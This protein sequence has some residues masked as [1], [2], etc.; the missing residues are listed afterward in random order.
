MRL[1]SLLLLIASGLVSACQ[2]QESTQVNAAPVPRFEAVRPNEGFPVQVPSA[3]E[4]TLGWLVVREDRTD[5]NSKEIRLPVAIIHG[6][7][8]DR[9]SPVVYLAG[10][11]GTSAMRTAA[12]P[13]AYPWLADRDFIVFGHRGTHFA[14]PALMCPEYR[15]AVADG[16]RQIESVQACR[17]RLLS[18][19]VDLDQ[20]N[21]PNIAAD[22]EDLRAT[23]GITT[24]NLYGGSYGTRLALIYA[25][26]YGDRID[27]MVLDSPLP[28]NAMY[29]D[30]S[31][32]NLEAALRAVARDCA[33][34]A[35]CDAAFP[36]LENRFFQ[37]LDEVSRSP[38]E[39]DGESETIT[40]P[41][42]AALIPMTSESSVTQAPLAMDL[43][44]RRDPETLRFAIGPWQASDFAWGMR[45]SVWCSEALPFSIR[46]RSDG[47]G[48]TLGGYESAAIRPEICDAWG[49]TPL[50]ADFV[51][52]VSSDVPTLIISGEFDPSTPPRWGELAAQTLANSLAVSVRGGSHSSTQQWGGDGCAMALASEFIDAPDRVLMSPDAT[53]CLLRR[54]APEYALNRD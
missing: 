34:Q 32:E 8:D 25:K 50:D 47:P 31:A 39:L 37:T 54:P 15:E 16:S 2:A 51:E 1:F 43:V 40:A 20:Y 10:G 24:W 17:E 35:P 42:L 33:R 12:F 27:S 38:I 23:L 9:K 19:G 21:S 18:E 49:V 46:Y 14:Q 6:R 44:A 52:P 48:D 11:P 13:G 41:R 36:D 28:P 7:S 5:P 4:S 45:F 26:N 29:D 30:Q 3:F 53:E 22:L